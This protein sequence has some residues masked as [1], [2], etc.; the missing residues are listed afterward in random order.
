MQAEFDR[1]WK[2]LVQEVL[3]FSSPQPSTHPAFIQL[4]RHFKFVHPEPPS[5]R[6]QTRIV[7]R[8]L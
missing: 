1:R 8:L 2:K 6:W 7:T 4:E 3:L 5:H